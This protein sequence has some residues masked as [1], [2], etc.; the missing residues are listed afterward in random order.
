MRQWGREM[1]EGAAQTAFDRTWWAAVTRHGR[2]WRGCFSLALVREAQFRAHSVTTAIVG[3]FQVAI[4]LVPV[5]LLY[6]YTDEMRGWSRADVTVLLGLHQVMTGMLAMFIGPNMWRMSDYI[7]R[8]ELDLMLI[9]PVNTQ[10][11]VTTRWIRPDQAF[12][13]VAGLAVASIGIARGGS[14]PD[15]LDIVQATIVFLAGF[16]LMTCAW[17]SLTYCA[18]WMQSVVTV[19]MFFQDMMQ[20]G[21]Y[22]VMFFPLAVRLMFTVLVPLAFAATFP[23]QAI[24]GGISWSLVIGAVGFAIVAIV[25]VRLFWLHAIRR[26]SSASS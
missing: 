1:S 22:P 13:V 4:G 10:F 24:T 15:V 7:T 14:A 21:R 6:S 25:F 19:S 26:Y 11:Y 2:L 9:R 3:L 17:S 23:A 18:F 20:A 16:V 8:G 12:N 5:L